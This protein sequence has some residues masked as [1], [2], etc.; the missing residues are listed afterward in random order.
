VPF[1]NFLR[2][3]F[4]LFSVDLDFDFSSWLS[5][6]LVISTMSTRMIAFVYAYKMYQMISF[7]IQY[8]KHIVLYNNKIHEISHILFMILRLISICANL[9]HASPHRRLNYSN[10]IT[11]LQQFIFFPVEFPFWAIS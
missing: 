8:L 7:I 5:A 3:F 2:C 4:N 10:S 6:K 1:K 9:Y 11:C